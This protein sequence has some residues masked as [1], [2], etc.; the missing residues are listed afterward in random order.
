MKQCTPVAGALGQ[1]REQDGSQSAALPVVHD[2]DRCL[3]DLRIVLAAHEPSH[4]DGCAIVVEGDERLVVVVVDLG[5]VAQRTTAELG[6][7]TQEAPVPRLGREALEAV[8]EQLLVVRLDR[9]HAHH[10]ATE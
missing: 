4:A 10:Q 7:R 9:A 5:Q 8:Q 6:H 2:G 3:G 1:Q